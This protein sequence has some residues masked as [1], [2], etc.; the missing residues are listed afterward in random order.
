LWLRLRAI[1]RTGHASAP[2][3]GVGSIGELRRALDRVERLDLGSDPDPLLGSPTLAITG[4]NAGSA[5]N[6]VPS[7][8]S[9]VLDVRFTAALG[10]DALER[11]IRD[12]AG[13]A[14]SVDRL[15]TMPAVAGSP[16]SPLARETSVLL[17]A[18][19]QPSG[20]TYFTDL[21]KLAPAGSATVILG[22]GAVEQA[23]AVDEH[24]SVEA[25]EAAARVYRG[26]LSA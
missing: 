20:A 8:A 25:I 10:C 17:G 19:V 3:A 1:G 15:G 5:P 9:A 21:S 23:H 24:C 7:D 12:A 22:P 4:L 26:L 13:A 11:G 16:T 18:E 6:V 2:P 14:I